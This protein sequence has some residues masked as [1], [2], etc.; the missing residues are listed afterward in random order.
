MITMTSITRIHAREVLDSRGRPT[1]EVDVWLKDVRGRVIV[2]S[3]ASTGTAEALELR[4]GDPQRYNGRGVLKAVHHVNEVIGPQLVG[5]DGM[6][7]ADIDERLLDMDGTPQKTNL[8]ANALL[9]VSLANACAAAKSV[10]APLYTY[11]SWQAQSVVEDPDQQTM[12]PVKAKLPTPMVN[13]ISGGLH[14]GKNLDFQDFLVVPHGAPG[15]RTAL[16]WMAK[17]HRRLG[18]VL[19]E[20]KYE[21]WLIGDE[22]GYGPRLKSNREAAEL[23][24]RAIET[25]GLRAGTD[26]SLA[27]DVAAS[28][29]F[30]TPS[31]YLKC[32]GASTMGSSEMVDLIESLANDFPII[33]IEDP[34][35]EDDWQGWQAITSRL[36][37]KVQIVGDDLLATNPERL[38]KAI[39]QRAANSILI[40]PN[41][42][43]TLTET[44]A[45]MHIARQA[46]FKRIVSA[47]SGES[48][49]TFIADLAVGTGAEQIKIGSIVR[50]ERTAKYNRLLRIAEELEH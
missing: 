34:L 28:H 8:G 13:M 10:K 19:R 1:V 50:G 32:G 5:C 29:F 48:E 39:Q 47:R 49:D 2:P 37:D 35:D 14:A 38:K 24:V 17:I 45:T 46:G 42:I 21:G 16:E 25:A 11:I 20:A 18:E 15:F 41:Q 12:D 44:L 4:D 26:V 6:D 22:G 43:G 27:I 23:L 40:K 36:G 30:D 7:Q 31:Y 3:G 33:S 9:G